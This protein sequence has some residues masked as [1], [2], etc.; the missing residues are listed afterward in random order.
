[1]S[2]SISLRLSPKPGALIGHAGKCAAQAVDDQRGQSLALDILGDDE[3]LLAALDNLL[4]QRQNLLN[5]EI[6]LS[7]IRL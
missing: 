2:R 5:E 6:F 1:M 7:V 3:Q 4:K